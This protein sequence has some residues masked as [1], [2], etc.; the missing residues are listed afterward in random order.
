M[1]ENIS[2]TMHAASQGD[3]SMYDVIY[4]SA[5]LTWQMGRL[6]KFCLVCM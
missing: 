6:A 3:S 5:G 4:T 1:L 2:A